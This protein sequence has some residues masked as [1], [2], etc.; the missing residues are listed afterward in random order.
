MKKIQKSKR[1]ILNVPSVKKW[2]IGVVGY[3]SCSGLGGHGLHLAFSGLPGVEIVSVADPDETGRNML[4]KETGAK[5]SYS[6]WSYLIQHDKPDVVCVCSRLPS[7][8][9]D[10]VVAAAEAGCHIYC[11]KP[12]AQTLEDADKMINAAA[13]NNVLIVVAHLGRY[14]PMY[15]VAREMIQ[16]GDIGRPLSV[17]CRGKE[18]ERGGGE[19]MM[20]LGTHLFDMSCFFFGY[21]EWIFGNITVKGRKMTLNDVTE[22][23]EPIGPV[24]GDEIVSLFGFSNSVRGYFESRRGLFD[25]K[26]RRMGISVAGSEAILAMRFD[27]KPRL[28][29]STDRRPF[30]KPGDFDEIDIPSVLEIPGTQPLSLSVSD[31][32]NDMPFTYCN[33]YAAVDLL[34]A[35]VEGREPISSGKDAR[36]ALEMIFGVYTSHLAGKS[37]DFPL[38]NR[39]HPLTRK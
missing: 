8:H 34:C 11:E 23:K 39:K 36:W 6:D 19:D 14:A 21:P 32:E 33:R 27:A 20:V 4:Q 31:P 35:I 7:Q 17:Y 16:K 30:E 22:P 18:D 15:Q 37:V 29:I 5:N 9:T 3:Y 12:F 2:R 10:V 28:Y 24:A 13:S 26:I 38:P 1:T 25:K